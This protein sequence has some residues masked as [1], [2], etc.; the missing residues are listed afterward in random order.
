MLHY[1]SIR[2]CHEPAFPAKNIPRMGDEI[3]RAIISMR[4]SGS[5]GIAVV[6]CIHGACPRIWTIYG[7]WPNGMKLGTAKR[8]GYR[9]FKYLQFNNI[10]IL[11]LF[12]A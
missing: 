12:R 7:S 5:P 8:G 6:W 3:A 4:N 11:T 9:K 10:A 2:H 1:S